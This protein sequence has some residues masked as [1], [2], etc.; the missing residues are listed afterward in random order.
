MYKALVFCVIALTLSGCGL[1]STPTPTS[2]LTPSNTPTPT[3]TPTP[4]NTP[5]QTSTVTPTSTPTASNTPT[6][7][8]TPTPSNTP[9]PTSTPT[10]SNTATPTLPPTPTLVPVEIS[11]ANCSSAN[12]QPGQ[13]IWVSGYLAVPSGSYRL[14]ASSYSIWLEASQL[15]DIR[16]TVRIPGGRTSNS[17]YFAYGKPNIKDNQGQIIPWIK[18]GTREIYVTDRLVTV[19]GTWLGECSL[20]IE[21]IE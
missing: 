1:A 15:S 9:T 5:T 19:R 18:R 3:N 20:E 10:P 7:T 6:P 14:N 21:I 17:M 11:V 2:T 4:S 8:N 13:G 16:M 12:V